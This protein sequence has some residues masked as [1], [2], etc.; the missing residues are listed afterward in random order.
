MRIYIFMYIFLRYLLTFPVL[1][2][3]SFFPSLCLPFIRHFVR[4]VNKLHKIV[5]R[6]FCF[7]R[8]LSALFLL[9]F[10]YLDYIRVN[11]FQKRHRVVPLPRGNL[12]SAGRKYSGKLNIKNMPNTRKKSK[13]R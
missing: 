1:T 13:G 2:L 6:G 8:I 4:C 11:E 9:R 3:L 7:H 5:F 12:S 10:K